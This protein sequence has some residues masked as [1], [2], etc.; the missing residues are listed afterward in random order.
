MTLHVKGL[1]DLTFPADVVVRG[2]PIKIAR[3]QLGLEFGNN[4]YPKVKFGV[5]VNDCSSKEKLIRVENSGP[6]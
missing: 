3:N 1:P 6:K 2:S 4:L 5:S